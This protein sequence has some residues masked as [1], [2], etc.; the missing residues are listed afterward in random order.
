MDITYHYS[1]LNFMIIHISV[2]QLSL[3][4]TQHLAIID[5]HGY[6]SI[7]QSLR[8]WL[9]INDQYCT[10]RCTLLWVTFL[11]HSSTTWPSHFLL[12]NFVIGGYVFIGSN[13]PLMMVVP[14]QSQLN[15][16]HLIIDIRIFT[17]VFQKA[18]TLTID[19]TRL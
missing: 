6:L 19:K 3:R 15:G 4:S 5:D 1:W 17:M 13:I 8:P 12:V 14:R 10:C 2:T 7:W 9:M 16:K 11:A 18:M